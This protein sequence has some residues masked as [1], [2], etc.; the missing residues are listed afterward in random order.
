MKKFNIKE[1]QG[2]RIERTIPKHPRIVKVW[3]W[4]PEKQ[5]YEA[6]GGSPYLARRIRY[7]AQSKVAER[8]A[9][10]DL[11][12][13]KCWQNEAVNAQSLQQAV[14]LADS[15]KFSQVLA[16]FK[17]DKF[18]SL[19]KSTQEIYERNFNGNYFNYFKSLRMAEISPVVVDE[20]IR[21]LKSLPSRKTRTS[22]E[23]QLNIFKSVIAYYAG[24]DDSFVSPVKKRHSETIIVAKKGYKNKNLTEADFLKFREQLKQYK[25]GDVLYVLSTVQYYQALRI[26]EVS[27]L[28]IE[29]IHLSHDTPEE[30]RIVINQSV[31]YDSAKRAVEVQDSFKNAAANYGAKES[32]L[33]PESYKALSEYLQVNNLSSGAIFKNDHGELFGYR[34]I[35]NAYNRAFKRA[36]L[37]FSGTHVMRHGGA[38]NVFDK[39][40]GDW[41]LTKQILGNAD[42]RSVQVYAVRATTALNKFVKSEWQNIKSDNN[43]DPQ[44]SA[45]SKKT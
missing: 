20:W 43:A 7:L 2:N 32:A 13:A 38:R 11:E 35:E 14:T 27:A 3:K 25:Y 45:E 34:Q 16:Q 31:R 10:A 18:P 28:S 15:P 21:Y 30:S 42:M 1:F 41:G 23:V 37:N 40:N 39:S 5:C 8:K 29:S 12:S 44:K 4:N 19:G 26:S 24:I 9:F 33:L 36:G 6:A 22:F 17:T